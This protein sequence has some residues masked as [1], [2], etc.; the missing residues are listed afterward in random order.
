MAT[1]WISHTAG[2]IHRIGPRYPSSCTSP[3][4]IAIGYPFGKEKSSQKDLQGTLAGFLFLPGDSWEPLRT[5]GMI[6][7]F[8]N[9]ES[10][11]S[12]DC[13]VF[14]DLIPKVIIFAFVAGIM[15]FC[16][17]IEERVFSTP[18][19]DAFGFLR[20]NS[21][22]YKNMSFRV[23]GNKSTYQIPKPFPAIGGGAINSL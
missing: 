16:L 15:H 21:L 17:N 23:M 18:E 14:D 22:L 9:V 13:S 20:D 8:F 4:T 10:V 5:E 19:C 12:H 11:V 6:A 3:T 7:L 1:S 2:E